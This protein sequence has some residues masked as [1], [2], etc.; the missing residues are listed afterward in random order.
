[1]R[2]KPDDQGILEMHPSE[3]DIFPVRGDDGQVYNFKVLYRFHLDKKK[4]ALLLNLA[5]INCS[6]DDDSELPIMLMRERERDNQT[7]FH[8]IEDEDEI[9]HVAQHVEELFQQVANDET[10][11]ET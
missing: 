8:N 5:E 3:D 2:R 7:I 4:Y 9:A 11:E 10:F 6:P 1:M